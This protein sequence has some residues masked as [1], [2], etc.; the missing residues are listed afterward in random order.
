MRAAIMSGT[1]GESARSALPAPE[2]SSDSMM[3][4]LR[5]IRS[6]SQPSTGAKS[7]WLVQSVDWSRP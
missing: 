5:P 1:L 6:E 2:H 3:T 7:V 4:G